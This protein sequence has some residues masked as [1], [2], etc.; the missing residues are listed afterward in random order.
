MWFAILTPGSH[1]SRPVPTQD[2]ST[3]MGW[4]ARDRRRI[5]GPA[6]V[7]HGGLRVLRAGLHV[8]GTRAAPP[9]CFVCRAPCAVPDPDE[10]RSAPESLGDPAAAPSDTVPFPAPCDTAMLAFVHLEPLHGSEDPPLD[11]EALLVMPD[12]RLAMPLPLE[13]VP[14]A[15]ELLAPLVAHAPPPVCSECGTVLPGSAE[16]RDAVEA[17]EGLRRRARRARPD[18]R[19]GGRRAA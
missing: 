3:V 5:D 10:I 9:R 15:L 1:P 16:Q 6:A 2:E 12:H 17:R 18:R 13:L 14:G 19:A 8:D 11:E 7:V 4:T